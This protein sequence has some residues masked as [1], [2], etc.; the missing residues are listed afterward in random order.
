M[1]RHKI[2]EAYCLQPDELSKVQ[3]TNLLKV[4]HDLKEVPVTKS[5]IR[6]AHWAELQIWPQRWVAHR[7][8]PPEGKVRLQNQQNTETYLHS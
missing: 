5:Y 6:V 4:C 7:D 8:H 3:P 2:M 1:L